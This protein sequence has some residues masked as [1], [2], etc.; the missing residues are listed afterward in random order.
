MKTKKLLICMLVGALLFNTTYINAFA[1]EETTTTENFVNTESNTTTS[2][3]STESSIETEVTVS[4]NNDTTTE[5][6]NADTEENS[7]ATESEDAKANE[8]ATTETAKSSITTTATSTSTAKAST[9]TKATTTKKKTTKKPTT[10]KT[11][12][13]KTTTKKTTKKVK[14]QSVKKKT[15]TSAQLKFL[16]CLIQ[17]EAGN[18]P[19]EGKLA[20]ANVVLNR[21]KSNLY[22]DSV[23]SVIYDRKW[24]V[25]FT[26]AYN[27][28]LSKE[29]NKYSRYNSSAQKLSVKAAKAALEGRNNIG[30]YKS[31]TVYS[32]YLA[33]K[34]PNH[35]KIGAHIF[36]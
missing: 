29:L 23:K 31:F 20:V 35:K 12:T 32:K 6:T 26:V 11:T 4:E 21:V 27:G 24:A 18:Q 36:F 5:E 33:K 8:T 25:Q 2:E 3:T 19:Y 1:A 22:P 16:T 13:K 14:T 34:H 10:K 17:A 30:K 9:T 15:Y 28:M 7:E